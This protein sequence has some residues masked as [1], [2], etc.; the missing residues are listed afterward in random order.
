MEVK[1]S[2]LANVGFEQ[3]SPDPSLHAPIAG[4]DDPWKYET[5]SY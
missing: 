3:H 4:V 2:Y 1:H 5:R